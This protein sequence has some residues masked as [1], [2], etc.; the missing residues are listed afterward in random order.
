M[1]IPINQQVHV[2]QL[3]TSALR[4]FRP[5]RHHTVGHLSKALFSSHRPTLSIMNVIE[6]TGVG[7]IF[8]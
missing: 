4:G 7:M 8:R 2:T 3:A 1:S 6:S 5:N